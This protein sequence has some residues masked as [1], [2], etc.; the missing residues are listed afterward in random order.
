MFIYSTSMALSLITISI[1]YKR[2]LVHLRISKKLL[3][4]EYNPNNYLP[5]DSCYYNNSSLSFVPCKREQ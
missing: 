4:D 5:E 2:S 3:G 1:I